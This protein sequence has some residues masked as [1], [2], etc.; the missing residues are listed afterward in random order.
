MEICFRKEFLQ[1][2]VRLVWD[3]EADVSLDMFALQMTAHN[4]INALVPM[5]LSQYNTK[6]FLQYDISGK[7]TLAFCLRNTLKK[8]E[9]LRLFRNLLRAW[10]EVD[11]YM[12]SENS[13]YLDMEYVFLDEEN[14]VSFV[15]LPFEKENTIQKCKFLQLI[16]EQ[17]RED[18][19]ERENYIYDIRNAFARG[20]I[21]KPSDFKDLLKKYE[22]SA[23]I[24]V[25]R[26]VAEMSSFSSPSKSGIPLNI[27]GK[28]EASAGMPVMEKKEKKPKNSS[29]SLPSKSG[30]PL[31]I[32]GKAEAFSVPAMESSGIPVT[33]KKEKKSKNSSFSLP[34]K[35]GIPLNI[36][37]KE[38]T[39]AMSAVEHI[40]IP[41]MEKKE[42]KMEKK[43]AG[44]SLFSKK[45][46]SKEADIQPDVNCLR[47][48]EE[49]RIRERKNADMYESYEETVFMAEVP[50]YKGEETVFLQ[51]EV[52]KTAI[53]LRLRTGEEVKILK[54]DWSIG[55]GR[56]TDYC[57]A[58]NRTISR[59]HGSFR[60]K[61]G[62]AYFIDNHSSNGSYVDGKRV[63]AGEAVELKNN[64]VLKL[65]DEEFLFRM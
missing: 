14:N 64:S 44:F 24:P 30:I 40:D 23:E 4:R 3:V 1:D 49:Q 61:N 37:G 17:L 32:P 8:S 41:A 27:P 60:M 38:E 25:V 20:A 45:T 9:V 33:E 10:E 47:Q 22:E 29:F 15:Y 62:K 35:S 16:A 50:E 52:I 39:S 5:Q 28:T 34:S 57:I 11:S 63:M 36:P 59:N 58:D 56:N 31:N 6:H 42:K 51:P 18:K 12:L 19:T 53:L 7:R 65:S 43:R 48:Q 13:L 54:S 46:V 21:K 55:S 26:N 2:S